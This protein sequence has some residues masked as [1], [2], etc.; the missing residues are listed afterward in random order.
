MAYESIIRIERPSHHFNN[1][2][3]NAVEIFLQNGKNVILGNINHETSFW[4]MGGF[5]A[6]HPLAWGLKADIFKSLL[7]ELST[8]SETI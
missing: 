2:K 1:E 5:K 7:L 3:Y 6:E 8:V 4:G